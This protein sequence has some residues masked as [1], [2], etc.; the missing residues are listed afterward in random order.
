MAENNLT[1]GGPNTPGPIFK[2]QRAADDMAYRLNAM[3][4]RPEGFYLPTKITEFPDERNGLT[5]PVTRWTL[6]YQRPGYCK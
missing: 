4:E 2:S 1:C 5:K 3:P 6:L